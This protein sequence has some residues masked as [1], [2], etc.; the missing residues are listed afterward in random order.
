MELYKKCGAT[1]PYEGAASLALPLRLLTFAAR[2]AEEERV[3][4][5][6]AH[7]AAPLRPSGAARWFASEE[8]CRPH[9][10]QHGGAGASPTA[11]DEIPRRCGKG[12]QTCRHGAMMIKRSTLELQTIHARQCGSPRAPGTKI[13]IEIAFWRQ[14]HFGG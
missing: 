1:M 6:A 14:P 9:R 8:L 5:L 4:G 13:E 11:I 12:G 2:H 7:G 3:L 10:V